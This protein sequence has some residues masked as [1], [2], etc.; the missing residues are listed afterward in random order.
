M[1]RRCKVNKQLC[2][3]ISEPKKKKLLVESREIEKKLQGSYKQEKMEMEHKAV[4]AIKRNSKY[5]Y[6][7]AKKFSKVSSGIGPFI[8]AAKNVI[9]N[10]MKMAEM[11]ADQYSSV[12]SQPKETLAEPS[13]Y[14]PEEAPSEDSKPAIV[15]IQF[16]SKDI[17][18]A[19][20]EISVT[21]AAGPDRFP[22]ILLKTLRA[23]LSE[24][25]FLIW[26]SSMDSGVIPGQLKTAFIIPIHKGDSRS[27]PKNYRPI[28]LTSHII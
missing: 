3:A 9:S 27:I 16:T 20:S 14:F 17:E 7:Y 5:F 26:R 18:E 19:I 22:A 15:D 25:L 13:E 23:N 21:A 12:F 4:G 10:P 8:D 2:T 6:A 11:L 28:A 1:R 24:P